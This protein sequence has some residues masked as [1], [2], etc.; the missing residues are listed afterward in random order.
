MRLLRV[1]LTVGIKLTAEVV[2]QLTVS[3]KTQPLAHFDD[4]GGG[5]KVLAGD[6]LDAHA[7][8]TPLDM[9]GNAGDHLFLVLRKQVRQQKIAVAHTMHPPHHILYDIIAKSAAS[10]NMK[11]EGLGPY[12]SLLANIVDPCFQAV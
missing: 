5:E 12:R 10:C 8:L 1:Y 2:V 4:G 9:R 7:L 6:L 11:N 3:V